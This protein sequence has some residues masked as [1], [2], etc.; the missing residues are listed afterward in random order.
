[1]RLKPTYIIEKVTDMNLEELKA[2]GISSLFFDLD[3]TLMPPKSGKLQDDIAQWLEVVKQNF[4]VV[5]LSN[6][7]HYD[8]MEKVA[9]ELCCPVYA[10]AHKPNTAIALKALKEN[11]IL[12]QETAMI[13][14]RP[15]TDIWVGQRLKL[16][17]IL[18]DPLMKHH[19]SQIVK[20]LRRLERLT[21]TSAQRSFS[22]FQ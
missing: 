12:P 17:T 13:G 7:P 16:V 21:V 9:E 18:V 3:N 4:Q 8:Y 2:D 15:L 22:S 6:N 5:V 1:M 20:C 19:E 11:N 10:K 14:D